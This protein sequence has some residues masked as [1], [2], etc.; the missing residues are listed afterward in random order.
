MAREIVHDDDI[1][2]IEGWCEL[3]FDVGLEDD[4]VHGC[5]D[6]PRGN[7]A[8][9]FEAGNEGLRPPMTK[10]SFAVQTLAFQ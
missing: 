4:A 10:R 7:E 1:A 3:G 2:R 5:I 8:V 6:H 9:T